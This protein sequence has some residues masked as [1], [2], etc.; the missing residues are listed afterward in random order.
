MSLNLTDKLIKFPLELGTIKYSLKRHLSTIERVRATI[1]LKKLL[2]FSQRKPCSNTLNIVTTLC[3]CRLHSCGL[4]LNV[5]NSSFH[6]TGRFTVNNGCI[7]ILLNTHLREHQQYVIICLPS[8]AMAGKARAGFK[9]KP[10]LRSEF[11]WGRFTVSI[12][13]SMNNRLRRLFTFSCAVWNASVNYYFALSWRRV[14]KGVK[15]L[16]RLNIA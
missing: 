13:G 1:S 4:S 9:A 8:S 11:G 12:A 14:F 7:R 10:N 15:I 3:R 5:G 2:D 16:R 6:L